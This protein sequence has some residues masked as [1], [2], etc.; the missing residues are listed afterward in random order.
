MKEFD[1][2][3]DEYFQDVYKFILSLSKNVEMTEDI[4]QDT[5]I[6]ALKGITQLR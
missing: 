4:I 3:Y 2:I 5:F 1:I 6:K